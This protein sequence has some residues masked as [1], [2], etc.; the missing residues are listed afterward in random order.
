M[1]GYLRKKGGNGVNA[2]LRRLLC[3]FGVKGL[4]FSCRGGGGALMPAG[5]VGRSG[6]F[7]LR[8]E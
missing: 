8:G 5:R 2:N 6:G 4:G 1:M 3:G 7:L